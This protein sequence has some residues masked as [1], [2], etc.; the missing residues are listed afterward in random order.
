MAFLPSEREKIYQEDVQSGASVSESVGAKLGASINH[1]IDR[2]LQQVVFGGVG[3]YFNNTV[4]PILGWG[5]N[6]TMVENCDIARVDFTHEVIGI[7]GQ[8]EIDIQVRRFGLPTWTSVFVQ[9]PIVAVAAGNSVSFSTDTFGPVTGV[10]LPTL[11]TLQ[12][13]L[14]TGDELRATLI[15]AMDQAE[16]YN[17]NVK[18]RAR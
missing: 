3:R 13:Q 2:I 16:N 12:I 9:K 15:S 14:F 18:L 1:I 8:T 6:E 10:T 17:I 5:S 4:Y 7:S 11:N